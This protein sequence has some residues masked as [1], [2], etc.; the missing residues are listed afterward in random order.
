M[1]PV[2]R[3][4]VYCIYHNMFWKK[5]LGDRCPKMIYHMNGECDSAF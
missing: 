3:L 2:I 4:I 5:R 1:L